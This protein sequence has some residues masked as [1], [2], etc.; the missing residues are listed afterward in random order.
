[1]LTFSLGAPVRKRIPRPERETRYTPIRSALDISQIALPL[2]KLEERGRVHGLR[3]AAIPKSPRPHAFRRPPL[4]SRGVGGTGVPIRGSRGMGRVPPD[5][6]R[7]TC[8]SRWP[9]RASKSWSPVRL[10][11]RLLPNRPQP[12][13]S[14][15]QLQTRLESSS[16]APPALRPVGSKAASGGRSWQQQC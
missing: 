4:L 8:P 10:T 9:D 7:L 3:L 1:M 16:Q 14:P 2:P 12:S 15:V 6:L 11:S 5:I 13:R